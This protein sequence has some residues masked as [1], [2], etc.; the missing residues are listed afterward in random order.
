[1]WQW[2]G[3]VQAGT[4]LPVP[5]IAGNCGTNATSFVSSGAAGATVSGSNLTVT[6]TSNTATLNWASFNIGAGAKV[7]FQ[8]PSST[9]IAL[10]R[11]FD[12]NP[13][14]IFGSLTA[15]GQIYL[16]N[17]NG[18]LFG[19]TAT[20][21]VG[22]MIASSLN[23][24][25]KTF[26]DGLL[27]PFVEN[28]APAL[29]PF[30][31]A[32]GNVVTNTGT[33]AVQAG[34]QITAADGG[35]LLLAAP[36]VQNAGTLSAPDGQIIL[37]AGQK[38]YLTASTDPSLRGLIVQVDGGG[39]AANQLSGQLT[40]ARGNITLTGLMVNQDG[41]VSATT[42]VSANGSVTLLAADGFAGSQSLIPTHGGTVEIGPDSS[43]DILPEYADPTTAVAAQTQ[44]PSTISITGQQVFMHGGS[45]DA[46]SGTLKVVA[47]ANPST[48]GG[49]NDQA[50]IRID[51]GTK[52]DL[53]GSDAELPMSANLVTVQLRS[54]ELADDP[55]QRNGAL[56]GDTVTIDVR[57][58]GG[59][60]T[61]IANVS[62]AI[63]A[64]GSNIAQRTET[65]GSASFQSEGDIVFNPGA[66]INVSGGATTYQGGTIQT[67]ALI[68]ANGQL[69]DIGSANPLMTYTGVVNPTYTQT[70][71]SWGVT[72][73]I[74]T[75][76]LSHYESGYV[77]GANAGSV[78]F[79]APS[80]V[81]DGTLK[82]SVVSGPYQRGPIGNQ[83]G[84]APSGGTLIIGLAGRV[85]PSFSGS[86]PTVY[87]FLAPAVTVTASP[88]PIVVADDAPLPVQTLQLPVSDLSAS[89]GFT[90]TQIYSNSSF[91]LPAGLPLQLAPGAS[92]TVQA[93]RIDIDSSIFAPAGNLGFANVLTVADIAAGTRGGIGVGNG[94]TLDVSG[95]WT[96]DSIL[97]NGVGT[98]PTL[99]N[100]GSISLSLSTVGSE[101]VLGNGAALKADGGAWLQSGGSIVYGTG[102]AIT[103]DAS[104]AQAA[105]QFGQG[106]GIEAFGTGTAAGGSLSLQ[107]PRIEI[108]QGNGGWTVAQRVDDLNATGQVLDLYTPLFADYG[109]SKIT[110]TANGTSESSTTSDVLTVAAGTTVEARTRSLALKPGYQNVATRGNIAPY[111]YAATLPDYLRPA[112]SVT[113]VADRQFDDLPLGPGNFGGID[114][115]PGAAIL[116]DA[117]ASI[118][119]ISEGSIAVG[120]TLRAPGGNLTL[121]IIA[122]NEVAGVSTDIAN[123][124]DTGYLPTQGIDLAHTAVLDA[125]GTTIYTPNTQGLLLGN[126]LPGGSVSLFADR[127]TVIAE[128]GSLIDISGT[129]AALDIAATGKSSAYT[130]ATIG[131]A[132]G[133]L[134]ASSSETIS[135]LGGI[136]A[137]GGT[138]STG[139]AAGGSLSL[140][141]FRGVPFESG[142]Q[143][144]GDSVDIELVDSTAANT[145]TAPES[146]IAVLGIQQIEHAGFD[147]LTLQI[148]GGATAGSIL[149]DTLTP[150]TMGRQIIF[151][152]PSVKVADGIDA[153]LSA[154]FVQVGNSASIGPPLPAPLAGTGTLSVSAG[155]INLLGDVV[156]QGITGAL[157][158]SQGDVQLLGTNTAE[159]NPQGPMQG[160]LTSSGNLTI[161]A[162]RVYPG[163]YTDFTLLSPAGAGTTVA[164]GQ[165]AP[166]PGTPLSAAG[167]VK[168]LADNIS[169]TGTLLAPFGSIDL[170]AN[171]SMTLAPGSLVS[172]SGAGLEVPFGQTQLGG[173]QWIYGT[174]NGFVNLI[175]GVPTKEV[176]LTAPNISVQSGATVNLGGGGDLYAYEWVP[177]TGGSTDALKL[178]AIPGLYAI[179]PADRGQAAPYNAQESPSPIQTQTVYLSG[180]AG[181]APGYYT[182]LPPR[183]ALE[184]GALLVQ[185]EPGYVSTTGGQIGALADGTPVIAGYVSFGTTG[186][187]T[188]LTEYALRGS[189]G[190]ATLTQTQVPTGLTEYQGFAIYPGSYGQQ[191]AAYTLSNAS[192]FFPALAALAGTGP[193]AKPAD[194]GT[195]TIAVSQPVTPS[196]GNSLNLQG[197]V[198]TAAASGGRG[199]LV[200]ISAPDLTVS[201]TE[202]SGS[203]NGITVL[204]SVLQGWD[205][206]MLTLGGTASTQ[207][208][209]TGSNAVTSTT[210][211]VAANTVTVGPGVSLSADQIE[212]VAQQSIDIQAGATLAST[213]GA[214]GSV[215]KALPAQQ[216]TTLTDAAGDVNSLPQGALLAVSDLNLP[217][218]GQIVNALPVAGR[219]ALNGAAGATITLEP[220]AT[221]ASGGAL[222]LDSPGNIGV[223]GTI[224]GQGASWSLSSSSIAFVGSG[225]STD[226]LNIGSSLL[227]SLQNAGSVRLASAG[228]I[229]IDAPVALGASGQGSAPTLNSLT[230]IG[231]S[232]NNDVPSTNPGQSNSLFG[233]GTLTLGGAAA[234][235]SDP[236]AAGGGTLSLVANNLI[237]GPGTLAING[238]ANT[239]AQVNGAL[240][241]QGSGGLNVGGALSINAV[242]ISAAPDPTDALGTTILATQALTIGTPAQLAQGNTLPTLIGGNL[243]LQAASIDDAGAIVMPS[244]L[245]TLNATN[246]GLHLSP[247]ASIDV[248]G[249]M[250][251]VLD[252][253]AG[254]PG[255]AVTLAASGN[256]TL[257][258]NST[259]NVAGAGAAP[260]G[261]VTI[262]GAAVDVSSTLFGAAG[263][264]GGTGG[265]FALNAGTSVN[266][267]TALAANLTQGGFNNA[268]DIR[269]RSG[270]LDLASTGSL[271]ANAIRL[272]ADSG[273]I[274][275]AG[276]LS[277]SSSATRGLI[278]LSGGTG[279]TLEATGQLHADGAGATGRGGQIQITST[280][281]SCSITLDPGSVISA[282]GS[283]QMGELV[284]RAPWWNS[285]DVAINEGAPRDI[286]NIVTN[287]GQ[288][289]VVPVSVYSTSAATVSQ[290]LPND[291]GAALALLSS[292]TIASHL[293]SKTAPITVHTGVEI[294]DAN[295]GDALTLPSLDLSPSSSAGQVVDLT[296]RAAGS[297]TIPGTISDGVVSQPLLAGSAP[298]VYN[299]AGPCASGSLSFVAGADLSS[300]DPLATLV[301]SSAAL[302]LGQSGRGASAVVRTGTGDLNLVAAG[303]VKFN[304]GAAAYTA[305]TDAAAPLAYGNGVRGASGLINFTTDSGNV[306][307]IAGADVLGS[308]V[309]GDSGDFSVTGWQIRQGNATTP[310]QYGINLAAF[311]WNTGALG[312][313]DVTVRAGGQ[314][315]NLSAAAA[316]SYV[317]GSNGSAGLVGAGGGLS[318]S[319]GGNIGSAQVYEA[320]GTATLTTG[321]GLTAI[322]AGSSG[323]AVGSSFALG[324][325]NI[326]VWARQ[327]V[328]VDA[329][330]NPTYAPQSAT[331]QKGNGAYFTYGPNSALNLESTD[332]NVLLELQPSKQIMGTL[333]GPNLVAANNSGG[334]SNGVDFL[335]LPSSLSVES[336]QQDIDLALGGNGGLLYPAAQ[337]QLTLLAARDIASSGG[338]LTM[339]DNFAG[340]V[341]TVLSPAVSLA[342]T[343]KIQY[344][345]EEFQGAIH[346]GDPASAL[347]TAGRDI[348]ALSLSVPKASQVLAGRDIVTLTYAG[349]NLAS[350]DT[351]LISAGRDLTDGASGGISV[352]GPGSVE[353]LTGRNLSLGFGD[354]IVTVGNLSNA[355]LA[356]AAGAD[357]S[358]MVGYETGGAN[359]VSFINNIV[360]PSSAYSNELTAYVAGQTGATGL[361]FAQA[362]PLFLQFTPSQQAALIDSIFFNELLLS[363]R[364]ANSGSGVGF[365]QGYA[366]I[367]A[368]FPNSRTA[369]ATG[370]DPYF[371]SLN[372]TESQIYTLSGGNISILVPGGQ[373][374]V[375]LA[376]P[377]S[378]LASKPASSLGIV[379]EGSG[380]VDIYAKGDVNVNQSRIFTLGGGNILIWSNEGSI[381]A[382][383]GSKSSLSVPPPV[384]LINA[385]GQI[386]LDYAGSLASGSG[387]RT[388]QTQPSFPAGDVDLDAPVGTVNAGDAGIGAAGNINIAAQ[389]VIGV[390]NI[391]FGGTATGV[392]AEVSGLGA[393]LSGAASAATSSTTSA[394]AAVTE[395]NMAKETVAPLAQNALNWLDV[396]VTGLGEENCKPSD[397]DCLKRQKTAPP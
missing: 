351:T 6:Q 144:P 253:H 369:S 249:T 140:Q 303:D 142:T 31:D 60:G 274:D 375:G 298:A 224:N 178:G 72:Q 218:V 91:T 67:T 111:L 220:G 329:V 20:V 74:P 84:D 206:S 21:N 239:Q 270:N 229:D 151:D 232:L 165:T 286:S 246:G 56:R 331:G 374:D 357:L 285:T 203:G 164:I 196:L 262:A 63:A 335:I 185:F 207:V 233:A 139:V 255:G 59:R 87:D 368:L 199:A 208:F 97:A 149:I 243:T 105:L 365:S 167:S 98:A 317:A 219:A 92:L 34:A 157:L 153:K 370:P 364:A 7:T 301:G 321:G 204:A 222:A 152:A 68:G 396:F 372:L 191:L 40:A 50:R 46:P 308:P 19:P 324:N 226:T 227:A 214:N 264:A 114:I 333:V 258:A 175:T 382:G 90:N 27:A 125:A 4:Q 202:P 162:A 135:L 78:Q 283:A 169:I 117:G 13:S 193:V 234:I 228:R 213:S 345:F 377:P 305:G 371:G 49:L 176:S 77:Q 248:A 378:N 341:P 182:L 236:F 138:G 330:Y 231:T 28:N 106:L 343:G 127:G 32:N 299:C 141:M 387:I 313:G 198:L 395:S 132:A 215:L 161:N 318:I 51:A 267:L 379:A 200:N 118:S 44:L 261:S 186:L 119:L 314:V 360:A 221:L 43:I 42:S 99:Q 212:I 354:G 383:N 342:T 10:N 170:E 284:L 102:G 361:T 216:I 338:G 388:I 384:V 235:S 205:A 86:G 187:H 190:T 328:Q 18:F 79:A 124:F 315:S 172:V 37:A 386:S 168:I 363:G 154:P 295:P 349:Q 252:Q 145:P 126:I 41:R 290:D 310:A 9:S 340:S 304:S 16:L 58:D 108:L 238:F 174:P 146:N 69:Y 45:I 311:D 337:G 120:G 128:T 194:A 276:T 296:V 57:A 109:F 159:G 80:L 147:S 158:Q 263:S 288:V 225:T 11:I 15:N 256:V 136:N 271:S 247:T 352:G 266:G 121:H 348:N 62:S 163:T 359:A 26:N 397:I 355:N 2:A 320:D 385:Q 179:L 101:L 259:I 350:G 156:L 82:G 390:S 150:L 47:A 143:L 326:T 30:T 183:Y 35:R 269:V 244:G 130:R 48:L 336:L 71:N 279:V 83:F 240:Q 254:T 33:I 195:L 160:S 61:P 241:T 189:A 8:Q 171:D 73:I 381:D 291:V 322:Q 339:S 54:N 282:A 180:G 123:F 131:S 23:I 353:V 294:Q 103:I 81:L 148:S 12:A 332:G 394:T 312:G 166:S 188:D 5:C 17:A 257:D 89:A 316:D 356:T 115:Q 113:L 100:A 65:G 278:D 251:T 293:T 346:M 94:V 380:N 155:Q 70:Y 319:A 93:P 36:T 277:A 96:N 112:A 393:T 192:S 230:L 39:T 281:P 297:I 38:V 177:G 389:H 275:I 95:Q 110:L 358:L 273:A 76:G 181:I 280:C 210:I 66:S 197:S 376:V 129:S 245:V 211:A 325:S 268:I 327:A 133:S 334:A 362:A 307:I 88:T 366:A 250:V 242:Q 272:S 344:G 22:G 173:Q 367:D 134:S 184:P 265:A 1:M 75:P 25:P 53:A 300:A 373:I 309:V 292:S 14:S 347:I 289:V 260:A 64:V 323:N 201:N 137:A 306:R 217:V 104:P 392:P 237:V 302:I 3:V 223:A 209:G 287:A 55:T 107:A 24:T 391:N 52:I 85:S 116:A 29:Q 122:P